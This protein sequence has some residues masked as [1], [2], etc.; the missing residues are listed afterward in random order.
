MTTYASYYL[1]SSGSNTYRK[2]PTPSTLTTTTSTP[3]PSR[4]PSFS[5]LKSTNSTSP[6]TEKPYAQQSE[7]GTYDSHFHSSLA[8]QQG[9][10]KWY[11]FLKPIEEAEAPTPI[12]EGVMRRPLF[13]KARDGNEKTLSGRREEERRWKGGK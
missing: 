8:K 7:K 11:D 4:T 3:L 1:L 12:Y 5:S 10:A 9:K 2:S 13:A 6:L